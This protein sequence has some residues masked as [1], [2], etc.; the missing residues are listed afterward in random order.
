MNESAPLW[1]SSATKYTGLDFK[2]ARLQMQLDNLARYRLKYHIPIPT[3]CFRQFGAV[4]SLKSEE[5]GMVENASWNQGI[6]IENPEDH[7]G[8]V[9]ILVPRGFPSLPKKNSTVF[10]IGP[11][12]ETWVHDIV[13]K[14]ILQE[15]TWQKSIK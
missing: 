15:N 13:K 1:F 12:P 4:K 8:V 7:K 6:W 11:C 5:I 14:Y 3:D 9:V 10:T 2:L